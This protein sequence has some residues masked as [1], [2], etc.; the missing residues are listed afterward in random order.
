MKVKVAHFDAK[1]FEDKLQHL[2]HIDFSLFVDD[3]IPQKQE[4]LSSVNIIVI[5]RTK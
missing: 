5:T 4:D 3:S 1:V 2:S